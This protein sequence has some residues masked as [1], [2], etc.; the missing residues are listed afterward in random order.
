MYPQGSVHMVSRC[1]FLLEEL[2]KK[3]ML[4][5]GRAQVSCYLELKTV[6]LTLVN[7]II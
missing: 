6:F 3:I 4:G 1:G 2:G 7:C 5:S